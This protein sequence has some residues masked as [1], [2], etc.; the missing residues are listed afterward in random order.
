MT[1]NI[2]QLTKEISPFINPDRQFLL[3]QI[4][5]NKKIKEAKGAYL[6]PEKGE[7]IL[8]FLA[9]YGAVPFGHNPDDLIQIIKDKLDTHS[10]GFIQPFVT[11]KVRL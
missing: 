7:P 2:S 11:S 4:K 6:Y 8:D 10:P 3:N 5:F 1:I 9:Q